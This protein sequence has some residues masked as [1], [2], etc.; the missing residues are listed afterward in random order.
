MEELIKK[1]NIRANVIA[2]HWEDAIRKAGQLLID[3]KK[4]EEDSIN[5]MI[6]SVKEL[7]PYIVLSQG[8]AL[9]H[10]APNETAV[11]EPCLSLVTLE[12]PIDFGSPNDPVKVVMC[13]A[14]TDKATHVDLLSKVAKK[15]MKENI[16]DDAAKCTSS[17]ELYHVIND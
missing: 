3:N 16:I 10:A 13:L 2:E 9:A 6:D 5:S 11:H 4:I 1:D 7:G 17:D 15:L 14:C 8:F 12:K